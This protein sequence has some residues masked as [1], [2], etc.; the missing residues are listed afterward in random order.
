MALNPDGSFKSPFH[1]NEIIIVFQIIFCCVGIPLDGLSAIAVVRLEE[2][3]KK[4]RHVF[5]IAI[6]I[7]NMLAYFFSL[8]EIVV[9]HISNTS[10]SYEVVCQVYLVTTGLPQLFLLLASFLSIVDR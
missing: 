3:R 6:Q 5:F 9:F 8:L 2:L 1:Q 10:K 4:P 7:C